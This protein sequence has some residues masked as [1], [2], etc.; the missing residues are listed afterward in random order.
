LAVV[1]VIALIGNLQKEI[2]IG[3]IKVP[4]RQRRC[5]AGQRREVSSR[6]AAAVIIV[7]GAADLGILADGGSV[8]LIWGLI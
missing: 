4:A 5:R 6:A 3:S 7:C 1:P 2:N 8:G